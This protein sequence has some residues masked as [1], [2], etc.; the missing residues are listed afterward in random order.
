VT[1]CHASAL[2]G[3]FYYVC[4][5]VFDD[6]LDIQERANVTFNQAQK[7]LEKNLKP[8]FSGMK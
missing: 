7:E 2:I 5:N 8:E 6:A 4:Q 1:V 3:R